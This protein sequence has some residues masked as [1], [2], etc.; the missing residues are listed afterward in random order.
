LL[1]IALDQIEFH[2]RKV[3]ETEMVIADKFQDILEK[4]RQELE[5]NLDPKDPEFI[6]LLEELKRIFKKKN[7][8][9]LTADEMKE[10]IDALEKIRK[11][12]YQQ[13]QQD[14]MLYVKYHHDVKYM[15]THKRLK[16]TPPV[17][18]SDMVIYRILM[19]VKS[20]VDQMVLKNQHVLD[21][22]AYFTTQ[23]MPYIIQSCRS[24]GIQPTLEQARYIDSCVS[25]EYFAERNWTT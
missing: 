18:G 17:I 2:F 19:D 11:A 20:A 8:E 13:N 21:N 24:N 25:S 16:E 12:A 7:I 6:T 1:N 5:R 23:I 9:E 15:R 22:H 14:Q 3:S 10:N 4:T